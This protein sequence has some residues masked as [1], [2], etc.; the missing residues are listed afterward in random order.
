VHSTIMVML[1][2]SFEFFKDEIVA[3]NFSRIITRIFLTI[4]ES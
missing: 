1:D 3:S 4:L 2:R